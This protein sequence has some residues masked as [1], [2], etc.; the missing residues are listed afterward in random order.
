[1][2]LLALLQKIMFILIVKFQPKR[3][4]L[5][6]C[7]LIRVCSFTRFE[8]KSYPARLLGS[9][10]LRNFL[11]I[12]PCSLISGC[13]FI[14]QVRVSWI[15]WCLRTSTTTYYV[16]LQLITAMRWQFSPATCCFDSKDF[17]HCV[18]TRFLAKRLAHHF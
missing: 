1:M 17:L 13:L 5:Q 12:P 16:G 4:K 9:A 11:K 8:K 2:N 10:R 6:V 7:L 3:I 15:S 14:K 18:L